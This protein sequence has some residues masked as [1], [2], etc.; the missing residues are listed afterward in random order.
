MS[1]SSDRSGQIFRA[2]CLALSGALIFAMYQF[3]GNTTEVEN[4][5]RSAFRWMVNLWGAARIY[6]GASNIVGWLMPIASVALILH[7]RKELA[8]APKQTCWV[9]FALLLLALVM[10][11]MG[12]RAQQTRLSILALALILWSIPLFLY[13]PRVGRLTLLPAA[14]LIYCVPLNFL[15]VITFPLRLFSAATAHFLLN[16]FGVAV[17]RFGSTITSDPPGAFT[18]DGADAASGLAALLLVSAF[19]AVWAGFR[20]LS[21][22]RSWILFILSAPCVVVANITRLIFIGVWADSVGNA[23]AETLNNRYSFAFVILLSCALVMVVYR[24]L[25]AAVRL[26]SQAW[27]REAPYPTSPS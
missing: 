1:E 27:K 5:S 13:G 23:S 19:A 10:H 6:G 12:A 26:P 4:Y 3:W 16:G 7:R 2:I 9:G 25:R 22:K 17:R 18:I 14:L 20:R 24:L 21:V 15:D 11:W 8:A